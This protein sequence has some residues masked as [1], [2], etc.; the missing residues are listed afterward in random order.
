ME[1]IDLTY[2][3]DEGCMTCGTRWH[4]RPYVK[5]LGTIKDVGRNTSVIQLGSHTATHHDSPLHFFDCT[6]SVDEIPLQKLCGEIQVVDLGFKKAGSV[7][8]M[9]D[10]QGIVPSPKMLFRFLWYKN[11]G[12]DCFNKGFP[13]FSMEVLEWLVK[14]GLEMLAL[15][16]PSPDSGTAIGEKDDSP[17]HKLLLKNQVVIVEYLTQTQ[18]LDP[19]KRYEIVALPL[20]LKG[21]DGS[22]ARVIV[23]EMQS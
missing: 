4:V 3:I 12:S 7:V 15:D 16:T 9:E 21:S 13:Y 23:R 14:N 18:A 5:R 6:Y 19:T 11:W 17:G 10:L 20:K 2:T 8:K 1:W 22:P